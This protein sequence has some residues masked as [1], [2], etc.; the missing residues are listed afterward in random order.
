M[1]KNLEIRDRMQLKATENCITK[2]FKNMYSLPN[3]IRMKNWVFSDVLMLCK[4]VNTVTHVSNILWSFRMLLNIYHST[5]HNIPED[6]KH[7]QHYCRNLKYHMIRTRTVWQEGHEAQSGD[8]GRYGGWGRRTGFIQLRA[9]TNGT[10][11]LSLIMSFQVQKNVEFLEQLTTYYHFKDAAT[12][13][14]ISFSQSP[15]KS[16]M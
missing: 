2:C 1:K 6:L 8:L 9:G 4:M 3:K 14:M 12:W 10:V 7:W 15:S 5:W 13:Q 16:L 11:S